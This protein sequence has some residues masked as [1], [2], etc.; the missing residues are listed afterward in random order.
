VIRI[1]EGKN[2]NKLNCTSKSTLTLIAE[3]CFFIL[4][5]LIFLVFSLRKKFLN[6]SVGDK[7]T[8]CSP[9]GSLAQYKSVKE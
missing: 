9:H 4:Q 5:S 7:E 6:E 3:C 8:L 2:E 1:G